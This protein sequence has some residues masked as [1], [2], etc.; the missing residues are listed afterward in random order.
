[1][2]SRNCLGKHLRKNMVQ[3]CDARTQTADVISLAGGLHG[4]TGYSEKG[5]DRVLQT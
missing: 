5:Q 1:M 4:G 3:E 2:T